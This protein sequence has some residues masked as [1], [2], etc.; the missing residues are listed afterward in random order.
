MNQICLASN[1][2]SIFDESYCRRLNWKCCESQFCCRQLSAVSLECLPCKHNICSTCMEEYKILPIP[3]CPAEDCS[4]KASEVDESN[5][6]DGICK[7]YVE[8]GKYITTSCCQAKICSACFETISGRKYSTGVEERCPSTECLRH[9]DIARCQAEVKCK[10]LPISGFPSK[11]E[12]EH[13][14]CIQCLEKM[15]DNCESAGSLPRCPNESCNALYNVESVIAMR[16]MLPGKSAFFNKLSLDNN[17]Y[18]LIK[19]EI[20]T[21]IKFS[22]NFKSVQRYCEIDV[23]LSDGTESRKLPFDRI[24]TIADLIRE[25][26]RELNIAPEEKVYG[27]YLTRPLNVEGKSDDDGYWDKPAEKLDINAESINETVE[28][29]NLSTAITIVA[30][31]AGIVQVKNDTALNDTGI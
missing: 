12:C 11:D 17:Y 21:P 20:V 26:R 16:A 18:Y 1:C 31:I 23:K 25:I 28:K 5:L 9:A 2:F 24:G 30:D 15:I 19:D 4:G 22:A 29:L 27:Y 7:K 8:E 14:M 13:A 10:N 6:C 3:V